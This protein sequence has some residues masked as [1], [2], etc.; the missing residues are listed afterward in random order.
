MATSI[1]DDRKPDDS[2]HQRLDSGPETSQL[3]RACGQMGKRTWDA[4]LQSPKSMRV[5]E[6]RRV[7]RIVAENMCIRRLRTW[8]SSEAD[9]WLNRLS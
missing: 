1:W 5:D 2:S 3:Q 8:V 9:L 7:A 6:I 4:L